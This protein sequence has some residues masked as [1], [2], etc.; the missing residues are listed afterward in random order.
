LIDRL[1]GLGTPVRV[2]PVGEDVRMVDP[3]GCWAIVRTG[4]LDP[5]SVIETLITTF[6]DMVSEHTTEPFEV[7]R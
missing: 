1:N 5:D 6:E 7:E 3:D 2:E 4:E